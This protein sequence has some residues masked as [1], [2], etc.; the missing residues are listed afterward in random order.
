MDKSIGERIRNRRQELG[1]TQ[2]ELGAKLGIHQ[3]QISAYERGVNL[4]SSEVLIKMAEIL[5]LSLDYLAYSKGLDAKEAE[6]KGIDGL[7]E[8]VKA[9]EELTSEERELAFQVL[10]LII[11]KHRMKK[12]LLMGG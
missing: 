6:T 11:L 5:G 12:L 8:R 10:D 9:L 1:L 3:K 4:P 2:V 7:M